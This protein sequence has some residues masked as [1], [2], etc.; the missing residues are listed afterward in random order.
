MVSLIGI[1]KFANNIAP[2]IGNNHRRDQAGL[3]T[4]RSKQA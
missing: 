4:P 3:V 1:Y 2:Q